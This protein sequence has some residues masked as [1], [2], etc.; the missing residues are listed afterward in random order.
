MI[1]IALVKHIWLFNFIQDSVPLSYLNGVLKEM[2]FRLRPE[3]DDIHY[4]G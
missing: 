2:I 1:L 4:T 3:G